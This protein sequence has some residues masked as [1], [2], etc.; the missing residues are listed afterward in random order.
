M[1]VFYL[2]VAERILNIRSG[3]SQLRQ[4]CATQPYLILILAHPV[5]AERLCVYP[6]HRAVM[7]TFF[8]TIDGY[9]IFNVRCS[10]PCPARGLNP[11]VLGLATSPVCTHRSNNSSLAS[12]TAY[13][14][15]QLQVY[16]GSHVR[17]LAYTF[18]GYY[19]ETNVFKEHPLDCRICLLAIANLHRDTRKVFGL[20]FLRV[21]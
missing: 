16:P 12:A 8:F 21:L 1:S 20:H 18:F 7:P 17:C 4:S 6:Y 3:C 15:S 11:K 2:V 14:C 5:H 9:R 13:V 10:S 19:K